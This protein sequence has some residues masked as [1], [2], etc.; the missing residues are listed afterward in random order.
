MDEMNFF[1]IGLGETRRKL[2]KAFVFITSVLRRNNL[3]SLPVRIGE[4]FL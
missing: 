3:Q 1:I 2:D 4:A